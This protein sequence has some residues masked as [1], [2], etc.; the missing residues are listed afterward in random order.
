M[1]HKAADLK[2]SF[3]TLVKIYHQQTMHLFAAVRDA[4]IKKILIQRIF[5]IPLHKQR[6]KVVHDQI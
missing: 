6:E 1:R 5:F 4:K 2:N 3:V